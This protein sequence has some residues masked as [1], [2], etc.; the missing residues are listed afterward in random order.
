MSNPEFMNIA[1]AWKDVEECLGDDVERIHKTLFY[2]GAHAVLVILRNIHNL[3][4]DNDEALKILAEAL[5][6]EITNHQES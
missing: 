6:D 1:S 5:G 4:K 2:M 3:H